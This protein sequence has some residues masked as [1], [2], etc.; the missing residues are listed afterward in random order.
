MANLKELFPEFYQASLNISDLTNQSNNLIVL[1]TNY[2]L[3]IIQLPTTVAKRY[4]EALEKVKDNIYIPYLVALEF[5]FQKSNIKKGK[6]KGL[7]KYRDAIKKSVSA[8]NTSIKTIDLVDETEKEKFTKD[9]LE[10]TA[11]YSQ[12]LHEL[13]NDKIVSIVTNEEEELYERLLNIINDKIGNKYEQTWISAVETDGNDRYDNQIPPGFDDHSKENEPEPIRYYG[14]IKYQ[15]K[16]GDLLIWKDI[17]EYSKENNNYGKK[18]I[19]VTNDGQADKKNDLLYKVHGL[20]VGPKIYMMNELQIE[21][22]KELHIINNLRLVQLVT[23][24]SD[25]E[26]NKLRLSSEYKYLDG[27]LIDTTD[28]IKRI[29]DLNYLLHSASAH[30]EV[31]SREIRFDDKRIEDYAGLEIK[32]HESLNLEEV[33]NYLSYLWKTGNIKK[34]KDLEKYL[35]KNLKD[36]D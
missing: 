31:E 32:E 20:T 25:K 26:I 2:L 34:Y 27:S 3:D 12:N 8:V 21:S 29:A 11:T 19:F 22:S 4:I 36:F 16:F 28:T 14:G 10:L 7:Q 23:D 35:N 24:L 6:I 30:D 9:I 18:V 33:K 13:I 15:R 17:I 1:D 5:N